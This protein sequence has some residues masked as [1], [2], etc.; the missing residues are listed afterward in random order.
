[1]SIVPDSGTGDLSG[2]SGKMKI[3]VEGGKHSYHSTSCGRPTFQQLFRSQRRRLKGAT[4]S[5]MM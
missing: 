3:I 2:I 4:R 5:T 1:M